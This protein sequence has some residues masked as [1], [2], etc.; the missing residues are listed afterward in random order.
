MLPTM[1]A[2]PFLTDDPGVNEPGKFEVLSACDF[3]NKKA[4]PSIQLRHGITERMD[5]GINV[6][7]CLLPNLERKATCADIN[8][9]FMIIPDLFTAS[10]TGSFGD[11]SYIANIIAGK[12]IGPISINAN[13]GYLAQADTKDVDIPCFAAIIYERKKIGIGTEIGGNQEGFNWWQAGL[14]V[15]FTEWLCWDIGVGGNFEYPID[16]NA[17]MGVDILFP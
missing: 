2:P 4:M 17:T 7:Y 10:F 15:Y 5:L 16:Y 13:I 1:A 8:L 3:W 11:P 9:K 12:T 6:G 14:R